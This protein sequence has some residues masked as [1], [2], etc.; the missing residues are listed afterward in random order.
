MLLS[1]FRYMPVLSDSSRQGQDL[2]TM[3]R[4]AVD[5]WLKERKIKCFVYVKFYVTRRG[6][7]RPIVVGKSAST[8]VN[9]TG[10]DISFSMDP[11]DG[12]ARRW[13]LKRGLNWY[14]DYVL[15]KAVSGLD[16]AYALEQKMMRRFGLLGS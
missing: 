9:A 5:L 3:D 8:L 15:V 14:H 16:E 4:L 6:T 7:V 13:L 10:S 11:K 12:R 2:Q 1:G